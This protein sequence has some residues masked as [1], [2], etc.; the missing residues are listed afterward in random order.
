MKFSDLSCSR[1]KALTVAAFAS[2]FASC[3]AAQS[4]VHEHYKDSSPIDVSIGLSGQSTFDRNPTTVNVYPE[5]TVINQQTQSQSPSPGALVTFHQ[6]LKPY[7]GYILNFGY[8]RVT[9][10]DSEGL[11]Y[12]SA[13][14]NQQPGDSYSSGSLDSRMYEATLAYAFYGPRSRRFRTLGQIGGGELFFQPI[15]LPFAHQ[16][17][18]ATMVFGAGGEYDVG[19]HFSLRAEYRGLLYRMPDFDIGSGLPNHRLFAVSNLPAVSLV[20]RIR[21]ALLSTGSGSSKNRN[22][23][24]GADLSVGLEGQLTFARNSSAP[25]SYPEGTVNNQWHESLSPSA[26][27]LI[28]FHTAYK[29]YLGYNVHFGWTQFTQTDT[30]GQRIMPG[31]GVGP[32]SYTSF[33]G[34]SLERRMYEMTAAYAFYGPRSRVFRSFGEAGAG[35]L[36]FQP[37]HS[38]V[39]TE[40]RTSAAVVFGA[41]GEYDLSPHFSVRAEYRGLLYRI[42]NS[43]FAQYFP[44]DRL[45]TVTNVPALSLVYRFR[46]SEDRKHRS[47]GFTR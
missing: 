24:P 41:G 23:M 21:P 20:Y 12:V 3:A 6:V 29:P 16:Q 8:T 47:T 38:H 15:D 30:L 32:Q 37:L 44:R 17:R 45:Y 33:S 14:G 11:G 10:N 39:A 36:V 2:V 19:R 5:W 7:L 42:N 1:L 26:G 13:Q 4:G 40:L 25:D 43:T 35:G 46:S 27:R 34:G 31:V 22:F 9:Q 18:R 28:T